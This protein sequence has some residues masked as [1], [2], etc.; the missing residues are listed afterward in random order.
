MLRSKVARLVA[1]WAV[2]AASSL[3]WPL[4]LRRAVSAGLVR[5][6]VGALKLGGV[7]LLLFLTYG[8]VRASLVGFGAWES[9]W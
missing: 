5:H 8:V 3:G 9:I 7:L 1:V 4:A 2:V 6:E